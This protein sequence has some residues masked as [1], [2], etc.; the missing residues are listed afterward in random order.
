MRKSS[1]AIDSCFPLLRKFLTRT[2]VAAAGL[3]VGVSAQASSL[4][5]NG[6]FQQLLKPGVASEFGSRYSSQQVTG[7]TTT[8]YNFVFTP[9][10]ADT[11]YALGQWGKVGLWG[12][13]NG[14]NNGLPKASPAGGNFIAMDGGSGQG[15]LLQTISGLTPGKATDVSFWWAGAQQFGYTGGT[16]EQFRVSLG[17]VSQ[18]TPVL[19]NSSHG[20]TGWKHDV[21]TFIPTSSTE[22]LSFFAIG[23]PAG[24]PPFSLLDGVTVN[25]SAPE[26]A[27][28]TL[29]L[30]CL[31]GLT[32]L[33]WRRKRALQTARISKT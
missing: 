28:W 10:S 2:A 26:P 20:F 6:N 16:T 8:G 12:P 3:A 11:T 30:T 17:S 29:G 1:P 5:V 18:L 15:A 22:V 27:T 21:M 25:G 24:V 32:V 7:W 31:L 23:T 14:S 9:G 33:G 4:V 13:G 19:H